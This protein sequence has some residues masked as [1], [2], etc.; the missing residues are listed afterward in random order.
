MAKCMTV[1]IITNSAKVSSLVGRVL[2]TFVHDLLRWGCWASL[3]RFCVTVEV[4]DGL[5]TSQ[6]VISYLA[7]KKRIYIASLYG[8]GDLVRF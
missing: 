4:A 5:A 2:F 3:R 7:I 6:N 8:P 1:G